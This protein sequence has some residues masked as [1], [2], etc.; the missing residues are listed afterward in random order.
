M[1]PAYLDLGEL[2]N[3]K[4][5][6]KGGWVN[7]HAHLDRAFTID[8]KNLK[9]I[10]AS[11]KEKWHLNDSIKRSSSISEIYDRMA[12]ALDRQISQGVQAVGTFIDVDSVI[13]DKAI[14]ASDK[15]KKTFK[16]SIK[17]KLSN[18][19]HYGVLNKEDRRWFEMGAN[20]VDIIGGLAGSDGTAE[21]EVREHIRVILLTGKKLGKMVNIHVDQ[22]NSPLEEHTK[23]L[24]EETMKLGMQGKVVAIHCISVAAHPKEYRQKLYKEMAK[25]KIMVISCPTGWIDSR[26]TEQL[27]PQ[28]NALTPIDELTPAGITVGLGTDNIA[29]IYKPFSNGDMATEL[30]LLYEGCRFYD[31]DELVNIATINGLKILGLR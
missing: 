28:H 30:K 10:N 18:Q 22:L 13:K 15:I 27:L 29:D 26:R 24:V 16:N 25:A 8:K 4:V 14:K 19:V 21:N 23:I 3:T 31:I 5:K 17:I 7:T 9:L 1:K 2:I 12:Y 6:E 11:L 20:Y